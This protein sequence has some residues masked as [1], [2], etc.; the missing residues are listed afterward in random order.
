MLM[1]AGVM[2]EAWDG[3]VGKIARAAGLPR[4]DAAGGVCNAWA[5]QTGDAGWGGVLADAFVKSPA[6][7]VC[8]LFAPGQQ[9]LPLL[10]ETIALLP[11]A[12]R[13]NVTFN[14][15]FTSMPTSATCAW[16]CCLAGTPASQ[17]GL[18]YAGGGGIV[19]D[20]TDPSRL[21]RAAEGPYVAYARTGQMPAA[22]RDAAAAGI[23]AP[24]SA[25][26]AVPQAP[27]RAPFVAVRPPVNQPIIDDEDSVDLDAGADDF[28]AGIAEALNQSE[29]IEI[30][31]PAAAPPPPIVRKRITPAISAASMPVRRAEEGPASGAARRRRQ[32]MMLFGGALAAI[33][34]AT[35]LV[36]ISMSTSGPPDLP[37][38][39]KPKPAPETEAVAPVE[40]KVTTPVPHVPVVVTP[41]PLPGTDNTV[42]VPAPKPPVVPKP[43]VTAPVEVVSRY[44]A[45]IAI[46]QPI[47]FPSAGRGVSESYT[48]QVAIPANQLDPARTIRKAELRFPSSKGD[49]AG[50]MAF[51]ENPTGTLIASTSPTR[52]TMAMISWKEGMSEASDILSIDVNAPHNELDLTWKTGR[53]VKQPE[54]VGRAYWILRSSALVLDYGKGKPQ[55]LDFPAF[56]PPP[57]TIDSTG[58]LLMLPADLPKETTVTPPPAKSLPGGWEATWFTDWDVKDVALRTPANA[59]QVVKFHRATT[60]AAVEAWFIVRFSPGFQRVESTFAARFAAA[61]ADLADAESDVRAANDSLD[62]IKKESGGGNTSGSESV[63]NIQTKRTEASALV[64]AYKAAVAGYNE[65]T[66]FDIDLNLPNGVRLTTVRFRRPGR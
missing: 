45:V 33:A 38:T 6:K 64:D 63:K 56:A 34:V 28:K 20:L 10:A 51:T 21:G 49:Y 39:P 8:I 65:L 23:K 24:A 54:S 52:R 40:P 66:Q 26:S 48:Q 3:R 41:A 16:R 7:P 11:A 58:G 18:R 14:T 9:V 15:Y 60:T 59:M 19:I 47:E 36:I 29:E 62:R 46:T 50:A 2:T 57:F 31:A 35:L 12:L 44:P 30:A 61:Q 22:V 32:V 27:A 42:M 53:L 4:G 25:K 43:E 37:P 5:A 17:L 1:Q 13:W 55:E